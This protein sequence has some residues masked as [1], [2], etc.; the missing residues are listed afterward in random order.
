V[1]VLFG[2]QAAQAW[3]EMDGGGTLEAPTP[4][5]EFSIGAL[6]QESGSKETLVQVK[7][8]CIREFTQPI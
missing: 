4:H 7:G 6:S 5:P 3:R 8:E 2:K 1:V